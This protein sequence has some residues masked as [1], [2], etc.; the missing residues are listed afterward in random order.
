VRSIH[1]S[2]PRTCVDS[3]RELREASAAQDFSHKS[4]GEIAWCKSESHQNFYHVNRRKDRGRESTLNLNFGE[5]K[6]FIFR[7]F[8]PMTAV[9]TREYLCSMSR[10]PRHYYIV[11]VTEC[12]VANSTV[13]TYHVYVAFQHNILRRR[14]RSDCV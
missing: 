8:D 4:G 12:R 13:T 7:T 9:F 2:I 6:N 3:L 10:C 5:K 1:R 11:M 14:A